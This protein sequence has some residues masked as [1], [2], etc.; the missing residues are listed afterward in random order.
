MGYLLCGGRLASGAVTSQSA[1][2]MQAEE[3][4]CLT[5][6]GLLFAPPPRPLHCKSLTRFLKTE[7]RDSDCRAGC[8]SNP[9]DHTMRR[10]AFWSTFDTCNC[11]WWYEIFGKLK[12]PFCYYLEN[13][14]RKTS[15]MTPRN[16]Y[17]TCGS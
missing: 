15:V 6:S 2:C 16:A 9:K 10:R 13:G 7:V 8:C 12:S 17:G 5:A 1:I 3:D 11:P 14:A 4:N